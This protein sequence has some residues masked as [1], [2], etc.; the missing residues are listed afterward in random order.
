MPWVAL[1]RTLFD[2]YQLNRESN[3][4]TDSWFWRW[5][6]F[7]VELEIVKTVWARAG[8]RVRCKYRLETMFL[9]LWFFAFQLLTG[10][11]ISVLRTHAWNEGAQFAPLIRLRIRWWVFGWLCLQWSHLV[12]LLIFADLHDLDKCHND[13]RWQVGL[14]FNLCSFDYSS[15]ISVM[16]VIAWYRLSDRR[17]LLIRN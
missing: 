15:V 10:R 6:R 13:F 9:L 1:N 11:T 14:D 16:A 3:A 8:T 12:Q 5:R 7:W 4:P 17:C 2:R